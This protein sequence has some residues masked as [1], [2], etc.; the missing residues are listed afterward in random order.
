MIKD[1]T[2]ID[3]SLEGA[4]AAYEHACEQGWTDGL[5]IVPPTETRLAAMLAAVDM[6]PD[7]VVARVASRNGEATVER[8]AVNAVMAGCKPEYLPVLVA[9]VEAMTDLKFEL[10]G[11]QTTT[12]PVCLL[13][14]VNG[15]VRKALDINC[16]YG[17]MG[18]GW[19]ANATIGRAVRLIQLNVGGA[20]P[21]AV[22][23]STQGQPGRYTFCFGEWEERSPWGPWHVE[24]GFRVDESTV[25]LVAATGTTNMTNSQSKDADGLLRTFAHSM[26]AVGS[27]NMWPFFGLG[28]MLVVLN[29]D[30]AAL[31]AREGMSRRDVQNALLERTSKV[32]LEHWPKDFHADYVRT[33]R[34]KDGF[35][36]LANRPEQ[37]QLIVAGGDSGLHSVFVPTFG[38]SYFV[39]RPIRLKK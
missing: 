18:P 1:R 8:I 30:H 17:C 37:F 34:A 19:R 24:R 10:A 23:K 36:P 4:Y 38:D 13:T 29:P 6:K 16:A 28:E 32:P 3:D 20:I 39:S 15:P 7:H 12:N 31:L 22:S 9:V 21:G 27:I 26:E 35:T 2:Q 25:T 11:I 14:V 5:P 33:G